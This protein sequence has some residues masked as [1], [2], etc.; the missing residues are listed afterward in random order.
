[1][2]I[3]YHLKQITGV[4]GDEMFVAQ[5]VSRGTLGEKELIEH[6]KRKGSTVSVTD[7]K[8]VIQDLGE[9]CD[10]SLLEGYRIKI[11]RICQLSVT[12]RG[13]FNSLED[14]FDPSEHRLEVSAHGDI[15][16][17]G[18]VMSWRIFHHEWA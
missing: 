12:I 18:V 15:Q 7:M 10:S 17:N 13:T 2:S 3:N 5:V 8:A 16:S 4:N 11:N 9:I 1:M 14:T 6:M